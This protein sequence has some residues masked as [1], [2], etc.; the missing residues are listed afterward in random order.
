MIEA[1]PDEKTEKDPGLTVRYLIFH[2]AV[3]LLIG[4]LLGFPYALA[5][6]RADSAEVIHSWRI[7]HQSL[8]IG[9]GLMFGFAAIFP[10]LVSSVRM[11][12]WIANSLTVSGY[13]FCLSLP[14]AA[15]T[16]DRGLTW[17]PNGFNGLV[18]GGNLVGAL[19][20]LVSA[21]LLLRAS[22]ISL[23]EGRRTRLR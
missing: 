14:L 11:K 12:K 21:V 6:N 18:F 15:L 3:V 20:S 5:I 7:A 9:A 10:S 2:G 19:A 1:P 8:P 17:S 23:I 16:S 13:A 22:F 4:L